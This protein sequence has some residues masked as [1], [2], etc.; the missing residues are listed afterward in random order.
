MRFFNWN[1]IKKHITIVNIIVALITLSISAL[2]KFS[3][4]P[5]IVLGFFGVDPTEMFQYLLTGFLAITTRL[6]IKGIVENVVAEIFPKPLYMENVDNTNSGGYL[7]GNSQSNQQG[8]GGNSQPNSESQSTY[9]SDVVDG[10][11]HNLESV[12]A[13]S[14]LTKLDLMLSDV[15]EGREARGFNFFKVNGKVDDLTKFEKDFIFKVLKESTEEVD[16]YMIKGY[17]EMP[18]KYYSHQAV[19][20]ANKGHLLVLSDTSQGKYTTFSKTPDNISKVINAVRE[21]ENKKS[22]N[23]N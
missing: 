15:L 5:I 16:K 4:L 10:K 11:H 13:K 7:S 9:K 12:W 2:F 1:N 22:N 19:I 6:G 17:P 23:N 18:E 14:S 20:G 21:Y 8:A 3:P